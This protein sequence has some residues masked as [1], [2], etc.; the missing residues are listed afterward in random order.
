MAATASTSAPVAAPRVS[1]GMPAYNSAAW[2]ASAIESLLSQT[3]Q[4]LELIISDNASTDGTFDICER[5]ARADPRV[6]L[7]RNDRNIGANLN[8]VTVLQAATGKY[9]KWAS[10]SD[11]CSARFV[12]TCVAA[13][14]SDPTAVL[15]CPRT[16]I[17]ENTVDM[18]V[19][20]EHDIELISEDPAKRYIDLINT[21][22]LNNVFNGLIRRSSL[23]RASPHG[24]YMCADVVLMSELALM[25]KFLRIDE[26]MFFRR[27]SL[28]TATAMKSRR[29]IDL[30][31]VPTAQGPLR[32]Q[33][34]RYHFGL[35]RAIRFCR[36]PSRGWFRALGFGLMNAAW[37]RQAL[38][39]DAWRSLRHMD[40]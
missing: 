10:S 29:D 3:F 40:W 16:Y 28:E 19:P 22:A 5:F 25:G 11:L 24:V 39:R 20:Y 21:L 8:Y 12:E 1:L 2:I 6:R 37:S 17:F 35:V 33:Y 7:L 18:A 9:F 32:W 23:Q 4:D 27:M 26:P 31:L 14:D 13:L 34:W 36:F 15:A 38:A 30:H